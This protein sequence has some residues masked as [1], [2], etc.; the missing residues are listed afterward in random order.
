M[1]RTKIEWTNFTWNPITGCKHNCWYC[2]AKKLFTRFHKSF[3]PQWHPKRLDELDKLKT[4]GNKIFVCS[5]ADLFADWTDYTWTRRVLSQIYWHEKE[6]EFQLLTKAPRRLSMFGIPYNCWV[7][8]TCTNRKDYL[9]AIKYLPKVSTKIRFLSF[10]PLLADVGKLNLK[11]IN[12]II[13]GKLTGSKKI[14][15]EKEWVENILR[16]AREKDVSVFIKNNVG[17][18]RKIQEFPK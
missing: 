18:K 2:Y 9:E 10:E 7:G 14:K 3:E 16:Q 17:W 15:L 12:W 13:I 11:K 4:R 1:N 8:V 6:Q 5:V